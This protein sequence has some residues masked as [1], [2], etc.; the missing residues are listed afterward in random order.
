MKPEKIYYS[1]LIIVSILLSAC[2]KGYE[3]R[4]TNYYTEALDSVVIGN[5]DLVYTNVE[6]KATTNYY[7][8][9]KGKYPVLFIPKS[10]K[11]IKSSIHIPKSGSG[12]RTIQIDAIEQVFIFE[13]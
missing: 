11:K 7:K 10:K 1:V 13:E 5:N 3:V 8:L 6:F 4:L 12:K 9:N 2:S